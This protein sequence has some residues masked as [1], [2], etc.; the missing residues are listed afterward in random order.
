MKKSL[1]IIILVV[2]IVV[3]IGVVALV[4]NINKNGENA[5]K[6]NENQIEN[7]L[8]NDVNTYKIENAEE[9]IS[10]VYENIE[11]DLPRLK[12]TKVDITNENV[13]KAYTGLSNTDNIEEVYA[14]EPMMSSQAYSFVVIKTNGNDIENLK[15]EIFSS[16][17]TRKWICVSADNLY[18]TN[19]D[20]YIIMFMAAEDWAEPVY[21]QISS[22]LGTNQ[23]ILL[24]R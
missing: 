6:E 12:T 3:I 2:A 24:K 19:S 16:V 9:F 1:K 15:Q 14:S 7:S 18:V 5:K 10:K 22:V 17:D 11:T 4:I 20:N 8:N 23:G 13:L 21:E